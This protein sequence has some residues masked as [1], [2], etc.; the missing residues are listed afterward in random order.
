MLVGTQQ[1]DTVWH[2]KA[3]CS[4][5]IYKILPETAQAL[6][7]QFEDISN[8]NYLVQYWQKVTISLS[9]KW[10]F[11]WFSRFQQMSMKML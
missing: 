10:L 1:Q 2:P 4:W 3:G 7:P 11:I 9:T 6:R 5:G 8:Y